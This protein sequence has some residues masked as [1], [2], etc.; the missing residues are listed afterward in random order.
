MKSDLRGLKRLCQNDEC[1][2]HYYDLQ[3]TEFACPHCGTLFDFE[4]LAR[5]VEAQVAKGASSRWGQR[6]TPTVIPIDQG[7]AQAAEPDGVEDEDA[8]EDEADTVTGDVLLEEEDDSDTDLAF[9]DIPTEAK[10]K[11]D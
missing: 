7:P 5:A 10:E 8:I 11:D 4:A 1:G 2:Q 9:G 3:R 6:R